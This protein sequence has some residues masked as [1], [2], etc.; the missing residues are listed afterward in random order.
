MQQI[1]Y[2]L[3]IK[4]PAILFSTWFGIGLLPKAPGTW[5]SLVALPFAWIVSLIGDWSAL[6]VVILIVFSVGWW[7]SERTA[8][9]IGLSDPGCIVIDEVAGQ[10]LVLLGTQLDLKHYLIG[11]ILFRIFDI[12]KPWPADW[13]DRFIKGGLGIMLDDI[14]AG[15]YGLIFMKILT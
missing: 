9:D 4:K 1:Y 2:N 13:A 11:F 8:S 7:A 6:L 3:S 5:G 10:C 12:A 15:L 14:I